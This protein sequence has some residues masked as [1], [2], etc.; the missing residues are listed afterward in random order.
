LPL[1]LL[2]GGG[3]R[4]QAPARG[5]PKFTAEVPLVNVSFSVRDGDGRLV[6]GLSRDDFELYE[7]GRREQI[8]FFGNEYDT[9]LSLGVVID[10]SRSQEGFEAENVRVALAFFRRIL[11]K[12]DRAFLVSFGNYIRTIC[13]PTNDLN[14]LEFSLR[15]MYDL[16]DRAPPI[17]PPAERRGGSAVIDAIYWTA[18]EKLAHVKGRKALIMIGDGKDNASRRKVYEAVE[19]LQAGDILFYGLNNAGNKLG[20][21]LRNRLP[22][23]AKQS[24]GR[25]FQTGEIS[26]QRA[27]GEIEPELRALYSIGYISADPARDGRFRRI[28]VRAKNP[29]Y[30]VHARPGYYAR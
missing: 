20:L 17:G 4:A 2:F 30:T 10:R 5:L 16:F 25:D 18:R 7:D 9:A 8:R 26:L 3:V 22:L 6:R 29:A 13:P 23:I 21:S 12:R 1:A 28:E 24:G 14:Q 27:F 15:N 11:R 19:Q